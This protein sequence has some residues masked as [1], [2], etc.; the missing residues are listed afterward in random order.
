MKGG[1]KKKNPERKRY[2][3][4]GR[5]KT[6]KTFSLPSLSLVKEGER[7]KK[8]REEKESLPFFFLLSL[9]EKF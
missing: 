3:G 2:L 7:K 5:K 1:K 4:K 6:G 9:T 8:S